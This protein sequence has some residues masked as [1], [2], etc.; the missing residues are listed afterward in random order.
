MCCSTFRIQTES[1]GRS[2]NV[3]FRKHMI[4]LSKLDDM[5][6]WYTFWNDTRA[7]PKTNGN[8]KMG[9][10]GKWLSFWKR[11]CFSSGVYISTNVDPGVNRLPRPVA[12]LAMLVSLDRDQWNALK[13]LE[14]WLSTYFKP[15]NYKRH[16][17]SDYVYKYDKFF[18]KSLNNEVFFFQQGLPKHFSSHPSMNP[19]WAGFIRSSKQVPCGKNSNW[20]K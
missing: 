17:F 20:I 3:A 12:A 1:P 9:W 10:V 5:P 11:W 18:L 13:C 16:G 8:L 6:T 2:F 19:W 7:P 15:K 14:T 4:N